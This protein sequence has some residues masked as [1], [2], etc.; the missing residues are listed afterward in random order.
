MSNNRSLSRSGTLAKA[1][2]A[3]VVVSASITVA[4]Q[5]APPPP[6]YPTAEVLVTAQNPVLKAIP[7]RRGFYGSNTKLGWG[8]DK[9]WNKHNFTTLKG[10]VAVMKDPNPQLSTSRYTMHEYAG[11]YTCPNNGPICTLTK[12]IEV[13]GV[14]NPFGYDTYFGWPAGGPTQHLGLQ[15]IY[16]I[17]PPADGDNCPPWVWYSFD[18][19]GQ[20][21]PYPANA[22]V[23]SSTKVGMTPTPAASPSPSVASTQLIPNAHATGATEISND[24]YK[25][26][27]ATIKA[28]S[29]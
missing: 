27:P 2:L 21:N 3:T 16:C 4:A 13:R 8:F 28:P 1:L 24:S 5:A 29:H 17:Q 14:Y 15:T 12:E 22:N 20:P 25:P 19:P 26:M 11:Y 10:M 23:S 9:G 7:I 6:G 18:Y